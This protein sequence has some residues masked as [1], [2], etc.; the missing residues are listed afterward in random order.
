MGKLFYG[1]CSWKYPS[2]KGLVYSKAKG[3]NYLA[4]YAQKYGSVEID[5]WFWSLFN[6]NKPVL[7]K[8]ETVAEYLNS[9]PDNFLFTIKAPNSLTLTHFYKQK[10]EK[11]LRP[12]PYF[13]SVSLF[14]DFL[15]RIERMK[16]QVG[17]L[18]FQFEYLN[19]QK[20]TSQEE[21]LEKLKTFFS[22]VP[23]DIPYALE[24][25]NPN[26]INKTHFEFLSENS[27]HHVFMQGYYMPSILTHYKQFGSL[28]RDLTVIRLHGTERGEIEKKTGKKW[29]KIVEP[30]DS[31][32]P[33]VARMIRDFLDREITVFVNVN[34]H[35]EGSSPLTIDKIRAL[36]SGNPKVSF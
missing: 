21:F 22:A 32:L 19:R 36:I 2:W 14:N 18:M 11:E 25:R 10:G 30:K 12:N 20:M 26:Y 9:V 27:L 24:V 16:K 15:D 6:D 8:T 31:E 29:D 35:Y 7:P 23:R 28:I 4:E 17:C 34:N 1:T 3:I 5:Q 33:A 13:L